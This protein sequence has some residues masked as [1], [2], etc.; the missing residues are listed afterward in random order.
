[1]IIASDKI[2]KEDVV[3]EWVGS[4][5]PVPNLPDSKKDLNRRTEISIQ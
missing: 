4:S 1:L 5:K 2:K 3:I